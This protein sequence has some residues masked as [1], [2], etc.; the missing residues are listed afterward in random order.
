[1]DALD[2]IE[3]GSSDAECSSSSSSNDSDH[4]ILQEQK[5]SRRAKRNLDPSEKKA[6]KLAVKEQNKERRKNKT[7]KHVKKRKEKVKMQGKGKK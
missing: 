3:S 7:P 6:H 2:L 5:V 4:G 1:M